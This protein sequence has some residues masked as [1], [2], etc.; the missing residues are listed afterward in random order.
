MTGRE[1]R[2]NQVIK[3]CERRQLMRQQ[4]QERLREQERTCITSTVDM[5]DNQVPEI[6]YKCLQTETGPI[7][8]VTKDRLRQKLKPYPGNCKGK[9]MEET[10][11]EEM[12]R[13]Q[14]ENN[15]VDDLQPP[16]TPVTE[17]AQSL[18][19]LDVKV[20]DYWSINM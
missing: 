8:M 1:R 9:L 14:A 12:R 13:L 2:Q 20:S 10:P 19:N 5:V 18:A 4:E 15:P 6:A 11:V 3:D 16:P 17:V 7:R